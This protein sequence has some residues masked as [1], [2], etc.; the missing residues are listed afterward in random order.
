MFEFLRNLLIHPYFKINGL[1]Y[2]LFYKIELFRFF[3]FS[4]KWIKEFEFTK[5]KDDLVKVIL[6]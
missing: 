2:V 4:D 3:N 6:K 1:K 5:H